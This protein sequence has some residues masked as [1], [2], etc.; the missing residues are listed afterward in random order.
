MSKEY[1]A[2]VLITP[3]EMLSIL[4]TASHMSVPHTKEDRYYSRHSSTT[5]AKAFGESLTRI[6]IDDGRN[7]LTLKT[8]SIKEGIED[9]VELETRIGGIKPLVKLLEEAGY[10]EYFR[11]T[12]TSW[13]LGCRP[14]TDNAT[15]NVE[16]VR[17]SSG[18]VDKTFYALEIEIVGA[19]SCNA[20]NDL[21][22]A[23]FAKYGKSLKD[24]EHRSWMELLS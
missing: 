17:V 24:A 12:K 11:K 4:A 2:K 16:L 23:E 22:E 10:V 5:S 14:I 1:E 8:K 9:N 15:I 18:L 19:E 20:L 13:G 3:E 6:R 21:L 7:F